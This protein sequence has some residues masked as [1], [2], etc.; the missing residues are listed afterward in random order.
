VN[1]KGFACLSSLAL[2]MH[3]RGMFH[4][5]AG[6]S[7]HVGWHSQQQRGHLWD[8]SLGVSSGDPRHT[9]A[10][11][12]TSSAASFFVIPQTRS[13][14]EGRC[15]AT[16]PEASKVFFLSYQA[17]H[18]F[19]YCLNS[20]SSTPGKFTLKQ[21]TY[22]LLNLSWLFYLENNGF[23]HHGPVCSRWSGHSAHLL[24]H[25]SAPDEPAQP[26]LKKTTQ[27]SRD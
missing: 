22:F 12:A 21:G 24:V 1:G 10:S 25:T 5:F 4:G 16:P 13:D 2:E 19:F 17:T 26:Q 20:F 6:C 8:G 7:P 27:G 11:R 9:R 23:L 18:V 14:T 15:S 3:N